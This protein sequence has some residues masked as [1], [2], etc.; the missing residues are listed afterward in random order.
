MAYYT[1]DKGKLALYSGD[2]PQ[3]AIAAIEAADEQTIIERLT[4]IDAQSVFAYSY[5]V[6]TKDGVKDIIGIGVDGAKEI[7][8]LLGNIKVSVDIR[9]EEKGDYF[10]AIVPVTNLLRNVTLLGSA[11]QPKYIVG[12]GMELTSRIDGTAFT[13]AISKAQRNGIL[14]VAPQETIAEIMSKLDTKA[15]KRLPEPPVYG[16]HTPAKAAPARIQ[17]PSTE[18][19]TLKKLRQQV[20]IEAGKVFKTEDER[21]AWQKKEYGVDSM[22]EL[23]EGKLKDMLGKI[24]EMTQSPFDEAAPA[25]IPPRVTI[26]N[27]GFSSDAEQTQMRK[28]LFNLMI[29]LGL[30]TDAEKI[31][32]VTQKGWGKT[33]EV[34]KETLASYIE[35]VKQDQAKVKEAEDIPENI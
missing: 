22:I 30:K 1:D 9:V 21:K 2:V 3:E 7:A 12:E 20:G 32:Y 5:P 17:A 33:S 29:G 15:I 28:E 4:R 18:E 13:K 35:A 6:R 25:V 8:N 34:T 16:K 10:Y 14:A 11:G 19:D 27:L 31:S 26:G 23:D 24:K